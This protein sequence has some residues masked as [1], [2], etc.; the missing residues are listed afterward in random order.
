VIVLNNRSWGERQRF[1]LAHELGHLLLSVDPKLDEE[2]VAH[3][4]AGALLMPADAL[5]SEIGKRRS[6]IGWPELLELKKIFGAS[7]QAI[8]YRCHDLEIFPKSLYQALY[9]VITKEGWRKPPYEEPHAMPQERPI[10]FY[11]LCFRALAEGA[12]SE[13][14]AAELLG[15]TV[16]EL[17]Q[18]MDDPTA[19]EILKKLVS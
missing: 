1:T 14:K 10:R 5:W 7:I 11:R 3:R 17:N 4:F 9:R 6:S 2:R 18:V 13:G 8:V 12:I 16:Y 15:I 19:S